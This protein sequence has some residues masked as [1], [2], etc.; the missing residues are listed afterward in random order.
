M[1]SWPVGTTIV[2]FDFAG[3]IK[4][5]GSKVSSLKEGDEVYGFAKVNSNNLV[6]SSYILSTSNP[7]LREA[8]VKSQLPMLQKLPRNL[9]S[10]HLLR[11]QPF[12]SPTSPRCKASETMVTES[13]VYVGT[14]NI[15]ILL[16]Q[17]TGKLQEGARVLVIGASGGCGL[18]CLQVILF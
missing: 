15:K 8:Y 4:Q 14:F 6:H 10:F 2:G 18:A 3:V 5:V 11:Q 9:Q 12:L 16:I 17:T 7:W 13:M 1:P